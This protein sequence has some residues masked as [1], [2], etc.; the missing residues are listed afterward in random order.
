MGTLWLASGSPLERPRREALLEA[1]RAALE[2]V[3]EG[4]QV[5]AT[6]PNPQMLV[7]RGLA[8]LVEPLATVFQRAW[9]VLRTQAWGLP[10]TP[11]RIWRV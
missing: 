7:V 11:P 8:P 10:N 3:P 4:V 1:V 5:A 6:C 9:A 2:G